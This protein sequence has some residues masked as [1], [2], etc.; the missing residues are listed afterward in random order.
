MERSGNINSVVSESVAAQDF[1]SSLTDGRLQSNDAESS[2]VV[3]EIP[4][5]KSLHKAIEMGRDV[6]LCLSQE[7]RD[8]LHL[9]GRKQQSLR[10]LAKVRN[11]PIS[12]LW[13]SLAIY[14]LRQRNPEI[15]EYRH[16]GVCHV[17]VIL[18]VDAENQMH[19]LRKT[20]QGRWSRARLERTVKADARERQL[21][22]LQPALH[23]SVA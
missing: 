20:E 14:L 1:M 18:A 7:S 9:R 8:A 23:A 2:A 12:T 11:I 19:Y 22:A 13:R 10:K 4:S 15:L 21:A 16:V 6:Y 3:A 17:S 5:N